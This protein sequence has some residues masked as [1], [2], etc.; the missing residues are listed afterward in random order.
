[1]F[2]ISSLSCIVKAQRRPSG[3]YCP[4]ATRH[5]IRFVITSGAKSSTSSSRSASGPVLAPRCLSLKLTLTSTRSRSLSVSQMRPNTFLGLSGSPSASPDINV[6]LKEKPPFAA[7]SSNSCE[8]RSRSSLSSA[9]A[10]A[11]STYVRFIRKF[12]ASLIS[13]PN[14][15]AV[16]LS[17]AMVMHP[18]GKSPKLTVVVTYISGSLS[19]SPPRQITLRTCW[20]NSSA[21][22]R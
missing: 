2:L 1:M 3:S 20:A 12:V 6:S 19:C 4:W 9:P 16:S 10:V 22:T 17:A 7:M 15:L 18:A 13:P 5:N 14:I 11:S 8:I 21:F